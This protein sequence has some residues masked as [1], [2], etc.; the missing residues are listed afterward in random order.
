MIEKLKMEQ[1]PLSETVEKIREICPAAVTRD[2]KIDFEELNEPFEVDEIQE[3]IEFSYDTL[4]KLYSEAR[5]VEE[6]RLTKE[7]LGE[8]FIPA[9]KAHSAK[10]KF[11]TSLLYSS[12]FLSNVS[13]LYNNLS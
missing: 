3:P 10:L 7:E 5:L 1:N 12:S 2:G 13:S 8:L 9:R 11:S 4:A 6:N